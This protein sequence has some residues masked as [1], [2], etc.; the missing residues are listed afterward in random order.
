MSRSC[1]GALLCALGL[2]APVALGAQ[3]TLSLRRARA[4][5]VDLDYGSTVALTR[6]AIDAGRLSHADLVV[7]YELLG[8]AA[9][10]LDSSALALSAF[11]ELITLEPDREPDPVRVSPRI[12][13]LYS[14]ALGQVLVVRRLRADSA[15]LV[16]GQRAFP[17]RFQVSRSAR[18]TARVVGA[19]LDMVFDSLSL[20]GDGA[21]AWRLL[22][23]DGTPVPAGRYDVIIDAVAGRERSQGGIAVR[24][25]PS[26]LDTLPHLTALPGNP[27]RPEYERPRRD[28]NPLILSTLYTFI[29]AG[30]TV[31]LPRT[32]VASV[33]PREMLYAGGAGLS[34]GLV[35]SLRRPEPRPIQLA[36]DY[37]RVVRDLLAR[38]NADIA[39]QNEML[40]R[41][42]VMT[43]VPVP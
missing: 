12:T 30:L 22:R 5:Y 28:W 3:D 31:S 35:L 33:L 40:R 15:T 11:R 21:A 18:V 16:A 20:A 25:M 36:I 26:A 41:Q 23:A 32:E 14:L 39:R 27:E 17:V 4:A 1:V 8:F 42:V 29:G 9:A 43:V 2:C 7:A 37:N 6:R 34:L 24:V 38:N 19:G 13:S 10:S